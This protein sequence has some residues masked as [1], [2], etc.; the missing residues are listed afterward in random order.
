MLSTVRR[1]F[2]VLAVA[3]L[4]PVGVVT[5][6]SAAP[7]SCHVYT[8]EAKDTVQIRSEPNTQSQV[9]GTLNKG[10]RI[11][12]MPRED[13]PRPCDHG[14]RG[15]YIEACG[16]GYADNLWMFVNQGGVRRYVWE[17]C[18]LWR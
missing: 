14:T 18:L 7:T 3:L 8:Y 9:T 5:P 1:T 10:D 12:G 16:K 2:A 17:G 15:E 6:A 4:A 11:P 13:K